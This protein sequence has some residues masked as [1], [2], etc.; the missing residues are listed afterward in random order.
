MV[1]VYENEAIVRFFGLQLF[2]VAVG[3]ELYCRTTNRAQHNVKP[4]AAR[5]AG[6]LGDREEDDTKL[7]PLE[8]RAG[9]CKAFT[10]HA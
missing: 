2:P 8:R 4:G 9:N 7:E 6:R 10:T 3:L 1:I 5:K